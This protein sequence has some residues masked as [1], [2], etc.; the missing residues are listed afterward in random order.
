MP[1]RDIFMDTAMRSLRLDFWRGVALLLVFFGHFEGAAGST[2]LSRWSMSQWYWSDAAE[3]FVF[4]SGL[5][6]GPV[7]LRAM[8]AHGFWGC[9]K[10]GMRRAG[11]IY[12]AN[13]LCILLIIGA[14]RVCGPVRGDDV[15]RLQYQGLEAD[16]RSVVAATFLMGFQPMAAD[17][18]TLYIQFTLLLPA[19]LYAWQRNRRLAAAICL[20]AYAEAQMFPWF[21]IPRW[22]SMAHGA[23]NLRH[24]NHISWN[25]LFLVGAV[26][27]VLRPTAG[28]V[29]A[30]RIACMGAAVAVAVIICLKTR[31]FA[32]E[33]SDSLEMSFVLTKRTL[34]PLRVVAFGLLAFVL[35][36]SVSEMHVRRAVNVLRPV[37]MLG[38]HSL[39]VYCLGLLIAHSVWLVLPEPSYRSSLWVIGV[40]FV[41][42]LILLVSVDVAERWRRM[43]SAD[44]AAADYYV[45]KDVQ[46]AVEG[47]RPDT[48]PQSAPLPRKS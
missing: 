27:G 15:V 11:W 32:P 5:V 34:G 38:Q 44:V 1:N 17:V 41:G 6:C 47:S 37:I 39:L 23:E 28:G 46:C 16:T 48:P 29:A 42:L 9:Q 35:F 14:S 40:E 12:A 36:A 19:A 21:N 2:V 24:F 4:L 7:Y 45:S 22:P 26:L 20:L 25:V 33:L 13:L 31:V 10:K 3:A 43:R 8:A 18:L 30:R